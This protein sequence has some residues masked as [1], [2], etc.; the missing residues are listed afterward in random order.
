MGGGNV[1]TWHDCG[2]M[3]YISYNIIVD[4]KKTLQQF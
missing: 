3:A 2:H 4:W 1:D